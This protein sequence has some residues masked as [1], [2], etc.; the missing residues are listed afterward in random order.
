MLKLTPYAIILVL[1]ISVGGVFYP[2]LGYLMLPIYPTLIIISAFRGRWFCGN[3]CPWGSTM[4][5]LGPISRKVRASTLMRSMWF[6]VPLLVA[7]MGFMAFRIIQ[8]QGAVDNIGMVF[9]TM[10]T[11]IAS[12]SILSGVFIMPRVWCQFCPM[13]T[14]QRILG[15]SKY[16]LKVD[17]EKCVMCGKCH[18]VCPM[19]LQVNETLGK[20]DCIKCGRCV[21]AC[22]KKALSF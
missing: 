2:K 20:P 12:V 19:Q 13:G 22:P 18:Q 3:F 11:M 9:V 14:I 7:M 8:T 17:R 5:L 1:I 15:G 10:S 6:R 4:D 16:Q 21:V